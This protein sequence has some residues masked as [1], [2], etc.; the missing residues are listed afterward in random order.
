MPRTL[1]SSITYP[2][3]EARRHPS[4]KQPASH[5]AEALG[6]LRTWFGGRA[7]G[8]GGILVLPTGSGKTFTAQRFLTT[9]PL[10]QGQKVVWLAHTHQLLDQAAHGFGRVNLTAATRSGMSRASEPS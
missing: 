5:Q 8:R 4:Q 2:L 6:K 10:S 9:L 7:E 1:R 3:A